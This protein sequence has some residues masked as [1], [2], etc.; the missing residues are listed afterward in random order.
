MSIYI[1]IYI[2]FLNEIDTLR[3]AKS[4]RDKKGEHGKINLILPQRVGKVMRFFDVDPGLVE[5]ILWEISL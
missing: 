4:K 1:S 3:K 5:K 2:F